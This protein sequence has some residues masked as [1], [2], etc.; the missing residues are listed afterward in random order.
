MVPRALLFRPRQGD[1]VDTPG[2]GRFR[3]ALGT[4]FPVAPSVPPGVPAPPRERLLRGYI[5]VLA[6]LVA[7]AVML[8]RVAH[9]PAWDLVYAEDNGVFLVGALAHPWH[10]LAPFGGY[11]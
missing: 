2:G 10:L 4:L 9:I 8:F 5:E 3:A 6:V 7:A 1:P 11:L